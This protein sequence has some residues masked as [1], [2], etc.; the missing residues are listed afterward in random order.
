VL[1]NIM[2]NLIGVVLSAIVI[3]NMSGYFAAISSLP[4][5]ARLRAH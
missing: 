4:P 2:G 3:S 5:H 1:F